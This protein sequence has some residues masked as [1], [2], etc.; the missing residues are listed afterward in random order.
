[1]KIIQTIA[2]LL[3]LSISLYS[4]G[5]HLWYVAEEKAESAEYYD[6]IKL[7][8]IIATDESNTKIMV[9]EAYNRIGVIY[10]NLGKLDSALI[11]FEKAISANPNDTLSFIYA[12]HN[13]SEVY[14]LKGMNHLAIERLKINYSNIIISNPK[15]AYISL[16][17][18]ASNFI[19][20]AS[21]IEVESYKHLQ[22]R[23]H[24]SAMVYIAQ[25]LE[26][27]ESNNTDSLY[28]AN[29]PHIA[30][31]KALIYIKQNRIT[32]AQYYLHEALESSKNGIKMEYLPSYLNNLA[33]LHYINNK[34]EMATHYID[35]ALINI[36]EL[37]DSDIQLDIY[38]N[39]ARIESRKLNGRESL[40]YI[41]SALSLA[42]NTN[43]MLFSAELYYLAADNYYQAGDYSRQ[44]EFLQKVVE[45][46][47]TQRAT[48]IG[49][50]QHHSKS[51]GFV[52]N[53]IINNDYE[54]LGV[55]LNY[56]FSLIILVLLTILS[57]TI[58]LFRTVIDAGNAVNQEMD[59]AADTMR[60]LNKHI[61]SHKKETKNVVHD[62]EQSIK[63]AQNNL[64]EH[65]IGSVY[66]YFV[67]SVRKLFKSK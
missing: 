67:C 4:K 39:K 35:L 36:K 45:Y 57:I 43:N 19:D 32:D 50:L 30:A 64:N 28:S 10:K 5:S 34:L 7:F 60:E 31:L 48:L 51:I 16:Y 9:S 22:K 44:Q 62:L 6:A 27:L 59:N 25:S 8:N 49:D 40:L 63:N 53:S 20:L 2:I 24:D 37:Y 55:P 46:K 1:M 26:V 11:S 61:P 13:I 42:K 56:I 21:Y 12:N 29:A 54:I 41:D 23:F 18:I 15:V 17:E 52:S 33:E 38:Y 47:N 66:D 14:S 3:F 65:N 58:K